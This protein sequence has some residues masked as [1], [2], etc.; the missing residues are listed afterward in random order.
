MNFKKKNE[1]TTVF[2]YSLPLDKF[3]DEYHIIFLAN[4]RF[5][6]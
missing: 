4:I 2:I 3:Y 1:S 5:I 6:H